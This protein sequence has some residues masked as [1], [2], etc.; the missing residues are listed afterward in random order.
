M[1]SVDSPFYRQN[2]GLSSYPPY[3]PGLLHPGLGGPTPFVP[4]NHL[5]TFQPKVRIRCNS[6]GACGMYHHLTKATNSSFILIFI[7]CMR[8]IDLTLCFFPQQTIGDA[9][10]LKPIVVCLVLSF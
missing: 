9:T 8:H 3:S 4:P 2:I 7:M 5:P 1:G 10:K 6:V